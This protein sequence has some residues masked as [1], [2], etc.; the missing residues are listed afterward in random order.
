MNYI[1]LI[2]LIKRTGVPSQPEMIGGTKADFSPYIPPDG[3]PSCESTQVS[4]LD[5]FG[6]VSTR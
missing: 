2:L 5:F 3:T 1:L 6:K 4:D